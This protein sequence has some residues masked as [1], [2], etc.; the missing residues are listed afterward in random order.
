MRRIS[1]ATSRSVTASTVITAT[2]TSGAGV[3]QGT[4]ATVAGGVATFT[5]LADQKAGAVTLTFTGGGLTSVPSSSV[6]VSA[7]AAS[8]VVFGQQPMSADP[9]AAIAPAVT[10]KVEDAFDNVV[11]NDGSTV[12]LTLSGGALEGGSSTIAATTSSGVATFSNLKIDLPGSYTL[13]ATDGALT[14]T[15]ASNRFMVSPATATRLVIQ[16]QPSATATAGQPFG[17]PVVV[18]EEDQFGDL[19]TADNSTVV[20]ATLESGAGPLLGTTT[21]TVSGGVATFA[22]LADNKAG[23]ISLSFTSGD[24]ADAISN[25]IVISPATA[26]QWVIHT[27]PSAMAIAGVPFGAQPIVYEEDQFGNLE[28]GDDSTA[29][30]VTL[31][32]GSG[33][34]VGSS[35]VTVSGGVATFANLADSKAETISL[36]FQRRWP[37]RGADVG[38]LSSARR[39]SRPAEAVARPQCPRHPLP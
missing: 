17:T 20:T 21:V 16:T 35:T 18:Y 24:L 19:E 8:K 9:G 22:N 27:Q 25:N 14:P 6:T 36:G 28:T 2:L 34:L 29:V 10:V 11:S 31:H 32:S 1:T 15:G 26:S 38:A 5:D 39:V 37:G 3:L 7:A 30:T 23:T 13:S 4:I 33:P 12:T